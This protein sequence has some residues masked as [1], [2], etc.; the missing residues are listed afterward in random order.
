MNGEWKQKPQWMPWWDGVLCLCWLGFY[1]LID[2]GKMVAIQ[3]TDFFMAKVLTNAFNI[4]LGMLSL[5]EGDVLNR[6]YDET[7]Y[8]F[9]EMRFEGY[10]VHWKY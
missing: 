8:V 2:L 5:Q 9:F 10:M 1:G 6:F 7:K 3:I 4:L